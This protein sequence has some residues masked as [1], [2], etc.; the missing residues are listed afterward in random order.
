LEAEITVVCSDKKLKVLAVYGQVSKDLVLDR[1]QLGEV[2]GCGPV[3]P[4]LTV[5]RV[6]TS[7]TIV[8]QMGPEPLLEAM[9]ATPDFDVL[10]A[11][12]AYDPAPFIAYCAFQAMK[13]SGGTFESL[14]T[15]V[16]GGFTHM[17]KIM[18]CGG[19]CATP[20]GRGATATIYTDGT[21]DIRP[22]DPN[23]KCT[24][25]SVA[26]HTL[27]EKSRPDILHG[28]GGWLDLT[29]TKYQQLVDNVSVR[30]RG[31]TFTFTTDSGS[32]YTVK[33]EGARNVG[34][35]T[36][37]MGYFRDP[38]LIG[39]LK[40]FLD[41]G[42]KYIAMQN[43]PSDGTW[44]LGFHLTG[45]E[46]QDVSPAFIPQKVFIVGE[47]LAETQ[48]LANQIASSA[49]IYCTHG[50]YS[51]QKGTSG[52]FA[53]GIGG[54]LEL[55]LGECAEFTIYHL[56]NL[57]A[58]EGTAREITPGGDIGKG[59]EAPLF[60]WKKVIINQLHEENR[61]EANG[62]VKLPLKIQDTMPLDAADKKL[63]I[64]PSPRFL[65]D[66]AKVIR[67]KNA[68][69]F[70]LTFDIMFE[71]TEVYQVVKDS[72]MLCPE[73]IANVYQ[74]GSTD[75]IVWCGFFDQAL[76]FKA[77]LPRTRNGAVICSGGY[78]EDDV[79]GSQRYIPLMELPLSDDLI[80]KLEALIHDKLP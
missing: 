9:N 30:V 23:A 35:R 80:L 21:F 15:D 74:V 41:T 6:Q 19:S 18:E 20:K 67:S 73:T 78:M 17:G 75:D 50:P 43:P 64:C 60:S 13:R 66:I 55:P 65:R 49:R 61:E 70:E 48:D 37:F 34:Y 24:I 39:Q 27:Y 42:R 32:P 71:D 56:I 51:N 25:L 62:P 58:G 29:A 38:I 53:M 5:E 57:K 14:G 40:D 72:G 2:T 54:Q 69:P 59:N 45:L 76:A 44:E 1:L 3:V 52:N 11:G 22:T 47:V 8:A 28:P 46:E 77:T 26:A 33:I 4:P 36:L 12:R 79:H 31:A 68:G 63:S 16:L 7:P 10:I